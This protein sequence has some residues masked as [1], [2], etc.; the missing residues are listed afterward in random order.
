MDY[1][2][3]GE[4]YL[5]LS[6]DSLEIMKRY[7]D[8]TFDLVFTSPPYEDA[9]TY[10]IGFNL[11]GKKYAEW[12]VSYFLESLRICKGLVAWVIEGK[13]RN[14][15]YSATP[16]YLQ[17]LLKEAGVKLRK[18][19][20]YVRDGVAGSGGPDYLKN[21]WEHIICATKNGK[22]PWAEPTAMGWEPIYQRGGGATNRKQDG[23]RILGDRKYAKPK[24]SNPGNVFFMGCPNSETGLI[25]DCGP[26]GGGNIGNELAHENEA[27]F[28]EYL[29]ECYIKTFCPPGGLVLDPFC[30]SGTTISMAIKNGRS[31]VG[32]DIRSEQI[33]LTKK[34]IE[35]SIFS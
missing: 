6:G 15:E 11:K 21:R 9:R 24:L 34:R 23:K 29:A 31:A 25:C 12:C 17:V 30:G 35:S 27:P 16:A 7:P 4:G 1:S 3:T 2:L 14:F 19:G 26:G 32:I 8:D 18:P 5:L 13:T 10:G 22:L 28:P 33:D 20:A